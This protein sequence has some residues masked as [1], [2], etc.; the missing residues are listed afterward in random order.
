MRIV[1]KHDFFFLI[2]CIVVVGVR[3]S[4]L[5]PFQWQSEQITREEEKKSTAYW[6]IPLPP[7]NGEESEMNI[8]KNFGSKI[9]IG[10]RYIVL[11]NV[12]QLRCCWEYLGRKADDS[13]IESLMKIQK[14]GWKSESDTP[15]KKKRVN[16]GN[17]WMG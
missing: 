5:Y 14:N 15:T 16:C 4:L 3:F 8:K 2:Y 17:C 9:L 13:E 10:L 12:I 6:F 1:N 7:T 11:I